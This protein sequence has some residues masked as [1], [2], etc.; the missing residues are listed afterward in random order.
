[1]VQASA[2]L[3]GQGAVADFL[4]I[5]PIPSAR[6]AQCRIE[7]LRL[8]NTNQHQRHHQSGDNR[9]A[10]LAGTTTVRASDARQ[11]AGSGKMR[12]RIEDQNRMSG[13]VSAQKSKNHQTR[14]APT[15]ARPSPAQRKSRSDSY[16]GL[17]KVSTKAPLGAAAASSLH[18]R[19]TLHPATSPSKI[20]RP[21][22]DRGR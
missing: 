12:C 6:L 18:A 13:R 9:A 14:L 5:A 2:L 1:M 22:K 3:A 10:G 20:T 4:R 11:T 16:A 8:A 21:M 19:H 17:Y 7:D 15:P